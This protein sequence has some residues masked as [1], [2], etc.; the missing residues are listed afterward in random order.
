MAK[1]IFAFT[2]LERKLRNSGKKKFSQFLNEILDELFGV[3]WLED[4]QNA[5]DEW[6]QFR[7]LDP[8]LAVFILDG[9]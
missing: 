3:G 8:F 6:V 4:V 9:N 7:Y 1:T 5:N 2:H